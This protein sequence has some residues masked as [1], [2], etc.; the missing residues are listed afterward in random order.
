M[1][2]LV[3]YAIVD[4]GGYI[5]R[6]GSALE[7]DCYPAGIPLPEWALPRDL[8]RLRWTGTEWVKETEQ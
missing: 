2:N 7:D 3:I 4:A 1:T 6:A 5:I 8:P